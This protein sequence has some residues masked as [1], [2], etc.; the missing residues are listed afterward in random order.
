M[1]RITI[2]S[3]SGDA[4]GLEEAAAILRAGGIVAF[5]TDTLYGIAADPFNAKAVQRVI[6]AKGRTTERALP[7]VAADIAQLSVQL[8]GLPHLATR[9]AARFWPGP[10]TIVVPAPASLDAVTGGTQSVGVRV[11]G[12]PVARALCR[13]SGGLL[14]ATSANR[15]GHPATADPAIVAAALEAH[16]DALLDGGPSPGGKPS[17]VIDVTTG[18]AR[19]VRAGAVDWEQV[20]A[21]LRVE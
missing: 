14:T 9:L 20:Q 8:G 11:P 2:H 3:T 13:A 7:L 15:T 5:P 17:T 18:E 1:K 16:L 10:L 12:H 19:L 21:C 6:E 4:A